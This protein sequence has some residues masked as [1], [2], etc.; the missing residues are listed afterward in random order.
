M[1]IT[2]DQYLGITTSFQFSKITTRKTGSGVTLSLAS[3]MMRYEE[4][5]P[6]IASE[7]I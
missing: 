4:S 5:H 3:K 1:S 6:S 2:T 7:V